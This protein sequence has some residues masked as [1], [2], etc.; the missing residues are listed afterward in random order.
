[1]SYNRG[2]S[3]SGAWKICFGLANSEPRV[4]DSVCV[5][6]IAIKCQH[7]VRPTGL[8]PENS[9]VLQRVTGAALLPYIAHHSLCKVGGSGSFRPVF[10]MLLM[11]VLPGDSLASIAAMYFTNTQVLLQVNTCD[12]ADSCPLP[13]EDSLVPGQRMNIGRLAPA[14]GKTLNQVLSSLG[15]E[16]RLPL[17]SVLNPGAL[18]PNNRVDNAGRV[19]LMAGNVLQM[20]GNAHNQV[21]A[22]DAEFCITTDNIQK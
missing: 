12:S 1:M 5:Y 19:V 6:V 8:F 20:A 22:A 4:V 7:V 11:Q 9:T 13:N 14:G 16:D 17:I 15:I 21:Q 3:N 18:V 2:Q 10:D